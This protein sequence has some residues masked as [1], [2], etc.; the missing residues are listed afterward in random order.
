MSR[1]EK[2]KDDGYIYILTN[3]YMPNVYKIGYTQREAIKRAQEISRATGVPGDWEVAREWPVIDAYQTEQYIFLEFEEY[4]IQKKEMFNFIGTSLE[5]VIKTMDILLSYKQKNL[6]IYIEELNKVETKR[7]LE[8]T[9]QKEV[10]EIVRTALLLEASDFQYIFKIRKTIA[11]EHRIDSLI[12]IHILREDNKKLEIY[13]Y[14]ILIVGVVLAVW[15]DIHSFIYYGLFTVVLFFIHIFIKDNK[16]TV[17]RIDAVSSKYSME[18]LPKSLEELKPIMA[19]LDVDRIIY[20]DDA[21]IVIK[22]RKEDFILE[23]NYKG[24][25]Y[26]RFYLGNEKQA[27]ID[28]MLFF[29]S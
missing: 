29:K 9:K 25:S 21:K 2:N 13:K 22:S 11:R 23:T 6:R 1:R 16:E 10:A 3:A 27:L 7:R 24:V 28:F 5:D 12:E 15:F 19:E 8:E 17:Q 26:S 4:R 20:I 18:D 14:G